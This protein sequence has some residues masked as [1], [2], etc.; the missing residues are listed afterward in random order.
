MAPFFLD[1]LDP[2]PASTVPFSLDWD[3]PS[4]IRPLQPRPHPVPADLRELADA[5]ETLCPMAV[6]VSR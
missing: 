2:A 3:E 5:V 1:A 4:G 6:Q